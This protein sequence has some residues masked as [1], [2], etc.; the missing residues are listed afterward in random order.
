MRLL[1]SGQAELRAI[2][3]LGIS[4]TYLGALLRPYSTELAISNK[5]IASE[6]CK[7]YL[8]GVTKII[9]ENGG[10]IRSFDGDRVM[11]VFFEGVKNT[12]AVRCGLQINWF[13]Q[14]AIVA[15]FKDYYKNSLSNFS[16]GQ[17]VGID[18]SLVYISRAGIRMNN[19]LI[20]VG[21]APNIAAKLSGVR[22]GYST[23]ITET[24]YNTMLDGAKFGGSQNQNMWYSLSW[25]DGG[26]YG[27]ETIYGS[28]WW[29]KP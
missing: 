14:N 12:N 20:W 7:A 28:T 13:F 4:R 25:D 24:V 9:R 29:W 11:G 10:E 27:V 6:V 2:Y 22:N 8:R 19:D 18:R 16:L 17:T 21:R 5:E 26:N 1:S 3:G 23:L 15:K